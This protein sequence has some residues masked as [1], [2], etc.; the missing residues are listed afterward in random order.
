[1]DLD[2]KTRP[3]TDQTKRFLVENEVPVILVLEVEDGRYLAQVTMSAV[4]AGVRPLQVARGLPLVKKAEWAPAPQNSSFYITF[5]P[6]PPGAGR[7]PP[8]ARRRAPEASRQAG[9]G[10]LAGH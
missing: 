10:R 1:M 2:P 6:S 7:R 3:T 4:P 8:G 5:H 9:T